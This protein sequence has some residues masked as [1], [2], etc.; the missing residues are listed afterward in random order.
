MAGKGDGPRLAPWKW[1]KGDPSPNPSGRPKEDPILKKLQKLTANELEDV[2]SV[3]IKGNI[4]DLQAIAKDK[5]AS[6][7]KVMLAATCV[8]I[9][10]RG[11]MEALDRLLN[12]LIGKVKDK[13]EVS[14]NNFTKAQVILTMPKNF[15]EKEE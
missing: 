8:K 14:G 2:A 12:R 7:I 13:V 1:K 4:D 11:D 9:I 10:S 6:V 3:I 5:T 15:S